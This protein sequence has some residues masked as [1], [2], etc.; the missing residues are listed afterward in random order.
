MVKR[1]VKFSVYEDKRGEHRYRVT[2]GNGKIIA[3]SAEGYK[4]RSSAFR[5]IDALITAI[6][7][8][9]VVV[10]GRGE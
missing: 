3:D 1:N 6:S 8:G 5:A 9:K 4:R 10:E 2:H 7:D